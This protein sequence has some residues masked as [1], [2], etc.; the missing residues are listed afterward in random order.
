MK[1]PR[2]L[3]DENFFGTVLDPDFDDMCA[4]EPVTGEGLDWERQRHYAEPLAA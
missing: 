3:F 4:D 1:A 2:H